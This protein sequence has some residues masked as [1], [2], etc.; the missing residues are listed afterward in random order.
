MPAE[1]NAKVTNAGSSVKQVNLAERH[2]IYLRRFAE[3][4]ALS[5]RSHSSY[6]SAS[7]A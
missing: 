2:P 6:N 4:V 5:A 1:R 7:R 3:T